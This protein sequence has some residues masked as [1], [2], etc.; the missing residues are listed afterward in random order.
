MKKIKIAQIGIGHD[1]AQ[2]IWNSIC[3]QTE[4]FD[5]VGWCPAADEGERPIHSSYQWK[6]RMTIEEVFTIA[7]LDAVTIETDD[8]NLTEYAQM[9]AEKHL[10]VHMDKPGSVS[11]DAFEKLASTVKNNSGI[12]H[13]GYMYRYNPMIMKVVNAARTGEYGDIFSVE[14][15]MD[16]EHPASKRQWLSHFKGGMLYFLG[17]HLIDLVVLTNG[18]PE[19]ITPFSCCSGYNGVTGEDI[20]MAVFQYK[21]GVSFV[22]TSAVEPGGFMRRQLVITGSKRSIELRPLEEYVP[23]SGGLQ[24]TR[25]RNCF[26][27]NGWSYDGERSVMA[28]TDRYDDMMADFA[29]MA[30]HEKMNPFSL[31]Y[32]CQLH[33][34]ILAACGYNIEYKSPVAL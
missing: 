7:D 15:H 11:Q 34:V 2:D 26:P 16:C 10:A 17:C 4:L 21:N 1:H 31:E 14:A 30:R 24:V 33:R 3:K 20:G 32:E 5:V 8:W 19:K 9:A 28:P 27:G 12:L 23:N 29:A 22:K 18:I 25:M 13:L 6:P